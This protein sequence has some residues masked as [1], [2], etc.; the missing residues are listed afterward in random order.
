MQKCIIAF[1]SNE[2]SDYG[3]ATSTLKYSVK[4]VSK[5]SKTRLKCS[6]YFTTPAFPADSGPDYVNAV[7]ALETSV[8]PEVLLEKLH[9][10]E[11][12]AGRARQ[13]RWGQRT[14]DLDLIAYGELVAPDIAGFNHWRNLPLEDQMNLAPQELILPHPRLQ[15]RAFVLVPLCDIAADWVHPVLQQTARALCDALPVEDRAAVV[16]LDA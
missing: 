12:S 6:R 2:I 3:D 15:D 1:G 4:A 13:V 11:A 8:P 10:I 9:Q 5:L 7:V 16:P 14:L